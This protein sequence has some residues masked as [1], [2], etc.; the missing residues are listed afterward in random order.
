MNIIYIS[1][2]DF[3]NKNDGVA[4]KVL[5]Q[6]KAFTKLGIDAD[7]FDY[8][9]RI[10]CVN[11]INSVAKKVDR[12]RGFLKR[13]VFWKS[14][15]CYLKDKSYDYAYIRYP[16]FDKRVLEVAKTLRSHG[17]R[18]ILEVPSFPIKFS[19]LPL[20]EKMLFMIDY[21]YQ[22]KV[23]HYIDDIIYIGNETD[24]IFGKKGKRIYNGIPDAVLEIGQTGFNYDFKSINMIAVSSMTSSHGYER[25]IRGIYNYYHTNGPKKNINLYLVGSGR[26]EKQ[27]RY[28]V[29]KYCLNERVSFCGP[30]CGKKLE[31][32]FEVATIGLGCFGLYKNGSNDV[33]S[34]KAKEYLMRGLPF[35]N[36]GYEIG[37]DNDFEFQLAIPNNSAPVDIDKVIDFVDRIAKY[38]KKTISANM[39]EFALANMTWESIFIHYLPFLNTNHEK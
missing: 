6:L 11:Y 24:N 5:T 8:S 25:I 20:K 4:K 35:V 17:T 27:Y 31:E 36:S 1:Q 23:T 9:E 2:V 21:F 32:L 28:L 38:D 29:K 18:I 10:A 3:D 39:R 7:Y 34:L 33:S 12:K 30:L 19:L 14:I 22:K 16:Y 15:N 13:T 26:S 37:I